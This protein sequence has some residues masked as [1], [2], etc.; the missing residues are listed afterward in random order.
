MIVDS[1]DVSVDDLSVVVLFDAVK[2]S[3]DDESVVVP[4]D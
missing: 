4:V 2:V 3:V 1:V